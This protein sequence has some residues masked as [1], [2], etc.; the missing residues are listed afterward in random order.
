[1]P[2]SKYDWTSGRAD[3]PDSFPEA[4]LRVRVAGP[5]ACFTRPEHKSERVSYPLIT[6]TAAAGVLESVFWKP[7]FQ[8]VITRIDVLR[9][10]AW[11]TV[12]TNE[13]E[14]VISSSLA[15]IDT[16]ATRQQRTS[17]L[18]RD[19]AY[20]LY[21]H[22]LV[23]PDVERGAAAKFRDQLRR[24]VTRGQAFRTPYLGMRE[25]VAD[26]AEDDT[27]EQPV[28]WTEQLGPML[29]SIRRDEQGRESYGWF[30][31]H[32]LAGVLL[33]PATAPIRTGAGHA[34]A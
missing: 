24:R 12:R 28:D 30:D 31:A 11:T 18:L 15:T 6:P 20:R 22:V 23:H 29:H 19:V 8:Y 32:V 33:V 21:A 25:M 14:A 17:L 10:P 34:V 13:T 26:I 7:E 5:I 1:M 2:A 27:A 4:P 9:R 3:P 16:A